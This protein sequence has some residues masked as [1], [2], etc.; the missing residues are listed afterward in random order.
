MIIKSK[1]NASAINAFFSLALILAC[2]LIVN[3]WYPFPHF[4]ING[5]YKGYTLL[6]LVFLTVGFSTTFVFYKKEKSSRELFFDLSVIAFL[7]LAVLVF[8]M[9]KLYEQRPVV[10]ALS[11]QGDVKTSTAEDMD[12]QE[13]FFNSER[14]K[15]LNVSLASPPFVYVRPPETDNEAG[16]LQV[17]EMMTD[18][19]IES[20][21]FLFEGVNQPLALKDI[22]VLSKRSKRKLVKNDVYA[23]AINDYEQKNNKEHFFFLFKTK[24]GEAIMVLDNKGHPKD[25]I[26][27]KRYNN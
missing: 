9:V 22:Q 17:Y 10:Q 13:E 25:Y 16:G 12:G 15:K 18:L 6:V 26:N 2:Y 11:Y 27:V 7:Q 3:V 8:G 19:G 23:R 14:M 1:F 24:Y 4:A 21:A 20:I 5:G